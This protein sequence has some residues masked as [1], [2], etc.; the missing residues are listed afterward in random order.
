MDDKHSGP[1]A[2]HTSPKTSQ[3]ENPLLPKKKT[4]IPH[5][6]H[7]S[8][9]TDKEPHWKV[10]VLGQISIPSPIPVL[11][12]SL[13]LA[14]HN[15][16]KYYEEQGFLKTERKL[17]F[18]PRAV[19][20]SA[21]LSSLL[22]HYFPGPDFTVKP[23]WPGIGVDEGLQL[24]S[25]LADVPIEGTQNFAVRRTGSTVEIAALFIVVTS[26]M[27][28]Q[29]SARKR[30]TTLA[31]DKQWIDAKG[32]LVIEADTIMTGGTVVLLAGTWNPTTPTFEFYKFSSRQMRAGEL[33]PWI[34]QTLSLAKGSITNSVPL[35]PKM[36]GLADMMF[37]ATRDAFPINSTN[38]QPS[39]GAALAPP[40][41]PQERQSIFEPTLAQDQ[42]SQYSENNIFREPSTA[43]TFIP[44]APSQPVTT[45]ASAVQKPKRDRGPAVPDYTGVD[46]AYMQTVRET[47]RGLLID[48]A[49]GKMINRNKQAALRELAERVGYTILAANT[50]V[51]K[52]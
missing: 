27:F 22:R 10:D 19:E 52:R 28:L 20:G 1:A 9:M 41:P 21:F 38:I 50:G 5:P 51:R 6:L 45:P 13:A 25:I 34:D 40:P 29:L 30:P 8:N 44:I 17:T 33:T 31:V 35:D 2:P 42:R 16:N 14:Y 47:T 26:P 48:G 39:F 23:I 32:R 18:Y 12:K 4:A 49:T 46:E 7:F 3:P 36:A 11:P 15:Y 37:K 24:H 43:P